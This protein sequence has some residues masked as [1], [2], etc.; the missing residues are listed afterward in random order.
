MTR[1]PSLKLL[2]LR[3]SCGN[4]NVC[5]FKAVVNCLQ[6]CAKLYPSEAVV[7][8]DKIIPMMELSDFTPEKLKGKDYVCVTGMQFDSKLYTLAALSKAWK[9]E[10]EYANVMEHG[11]SCTHYYSPFQ[12]NQNC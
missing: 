10:Y 3:S 7:D 11:K 5:S 4:I 9:K 6:V 2:G 1:M 8:D 12:Y